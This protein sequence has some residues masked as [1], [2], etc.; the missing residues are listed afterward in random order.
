MKKS[1]DF[2]MQEA[3]R[4]AKSPSGQQLLSLLR[5]LNKD[6]LQQASS[7]AASGN[8]ADAAA[9]LQPLL[10][11]EEVQKLLKQMGGK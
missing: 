5:N 4:L 7:Q 1:Q 9:A 3:E 8:Y 11:S 2:S 6:A 10:Q